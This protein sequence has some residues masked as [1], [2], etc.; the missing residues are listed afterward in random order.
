MTNLVPELPITKWATPALA[1]G[2]I[3]NMDNS[4]AQVECAGG[5]RNNVWILLSIAFN[6]G[7]GMSMRPI[8]FSS[9]RD[10]SHWNK[11]IKKIAW[12]R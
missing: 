5:S 8:G 9:L 11:K 7:G 1:L 2:I 10:T 6:E 12:V 3:Q 4:Q